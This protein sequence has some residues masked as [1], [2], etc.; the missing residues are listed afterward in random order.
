MLIATQ[1][2]RWAWLFLPGPLLSWPLCSYLSLILSFFLSFSLLDF[3]LFMLAFLFFPLCFLGKETNNVATV[4]ILNSK[5][6]KCRGNSCSV[7]QGYTAS[8]I[9]CRRSKHKGNKTVLALN[10]THK[11]EALIRWFWVLHS[12]SCFL[13]SLSNFSF[14]GQTALLS[15]KY[16]AH[17][18]EKILTDFQC[19][20]NIK[21]KKTEMNLASSLT[22]PEVPSLC[23]LYFQAHPTSLALCSLQESF[24]FPAVPLQ[25]FPLPNV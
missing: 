13:T 11:E 12:S 22:E 3:C 24:R 1:Q 23:H 21:Q 18:V 17:T 16:W 25:L 19:F 2:P 9:F 5:N 14:A 7:E 8:H 15:N 6:F 10:V 20:L 4:N